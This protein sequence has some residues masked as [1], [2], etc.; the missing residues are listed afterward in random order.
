MFPEGGNAL[1]TSPHPLVLS[2][3]D[4]SITFL[5]LKGRLWSQA[6]WVQSPALPLVAVEPGASCLP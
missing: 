1:T 6:A 3:T 4:T 5:E 2:V